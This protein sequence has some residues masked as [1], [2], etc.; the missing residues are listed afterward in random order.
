[1]EKKKISPEVIARTICLTVALA[2]QAL[3]ICGKEALPFKDD[4]IYQ[5]VSVV[6]TI[7]TSAWAWWKN[8]SFTQAAISGDELMKELK[9]ST[10]DE[11]AD[12]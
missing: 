7:V 10:D 11:E 8:N 12:F 5:A 9:E 2:N 1:M 6:A 4:T 3:A